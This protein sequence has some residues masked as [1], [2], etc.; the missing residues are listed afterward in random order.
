MHDIIITLLDVHYVGCPWVVHALVL[1]MGG[2]TNCKMETVV[3][4]A[5]AVVHEVFHGSFSHS[6]S[7]PSAEM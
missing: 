3:H 2:K 7:F 5:C 4:A 1:S 6:A